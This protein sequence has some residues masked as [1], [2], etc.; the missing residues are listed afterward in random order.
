MSEFMSEPYPFIIAASVVLIISFLFGELSKATSVPSV[1]MLIVFGAVIKLGMDHFGYSD[2]EFLPILKILGTVGLIMI[3][4]EAALEL[5]LER[6]KIVP[7]LLAMG[8]ALVGLLLS[9]WVTAEIL[10]YFLDFKG[11][12][13]EYSKIEAWLYATPLSIL[14]SA[15]IIPSVVNLRGDKK[16]FHIY[17]STFSDILGIMLFEV[18]KNMIPE[19]GA[20]H[21]AS[22]LGTFGFKFLLIIV[23]SI[24]FSYAIVLVF[25][26]ITSSAKLFLLIATLL[27]MYSVGNL[28]HLSSLIIILIFGLVIAN[29]DLFFVGP[30]KKW[31]DKKKAHDIYH[32]LHVITLETAFVVRTFFFVVFG[33]TI[34]FSTLASWELLGISLLC[35]AVI[36]LIRFLLLRASL[37]PDI[38]PQVW[39]APRGLILLVRVS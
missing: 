23:I 14:S 36:Y 25:Q 1:L 38:N 2:Q 8:I 20:E 24:F 10:H 37:G 12:F 22:G 3:V 5:K 9:T 26:R 11:A 16:E 18:I 6:S 39:I 31:L 34:I 33:M 21:A 28:L 27:L 7:I 30:L 35:I 17:E 29:M 19:E 13:C 32:G 4:L 15:I